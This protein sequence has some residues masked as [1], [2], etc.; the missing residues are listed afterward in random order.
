M[1]SDQVQVH[2][3]AVI[4]CEMSYEINR[5]M[6]C[7]PHK[8]MTSSVSF[9]V[10]NIKHER[11][12]LCGSQF[13]SFIKFHT[14]LAHFLNLCPQD[15]WLELNSPLRW[16]SLVSGH[17]RVWC[18]YQDCLYPAMQ[19]NSMKLHDRWHVDREHLW[20]DKCIP[21]AFW[22]LKYWMYETW[23]KRTFKVNVD[24]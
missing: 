23:I 15:H 13:W 19:D 9:C 7:L 11:P 8:L 14:I 3:L 21:C 16:S 10:Q 24:D 4:K 1:L 22:L 2:S 12:C 6:W 20:L 18:C 17:N 5:K